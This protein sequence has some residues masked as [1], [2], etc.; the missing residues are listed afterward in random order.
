MSKRENWEPRLSKLDNILNM[1]KTRALSFIGKALI[2]NVLGIS[3]LMHVARVLI[4]PRWVL[5][6]LNKFNLVFL[7]GEQK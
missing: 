3:K 2:V 7:Y 1:W 6:K 5:D 4:P